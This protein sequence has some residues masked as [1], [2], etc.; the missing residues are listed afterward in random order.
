MNDQ[1]TFHTILK[2]NEKFRNLWLAQFI[3]SIGD[4]ANN[5]AVLAL[6][7]HL[8]DSGLQAGLVILAGN[9]AAIVAGPLGGSL[10]DKWNPKPILIIS[11]LLGALLSLGYL[12]INESGQII[13]V[14]ILGGMLTI[15]L[16]VFQIAYGVT[17]PLVA[18]RKELLIAN[19]LIGIS[20][21]FV[22]AIGSLLGG[23][24]STTFG[25]HIPFI[26]NCGTFLISALLIFP[27][28]VA[29]ISSDAKGDHIKTQSQKSLFQYLRQSP[30]EFSTLFLKPS[31]ALG[32][33][34]IIL[35]VLFSIEIFESGDIGTGLLYGA[36]GG[37]FVLSAI[38]L[39]YIR[40]KSTNQMI[41]YIAGSFAIL[42]FGYM[43][44]AY[45]PNLI[46]GV[47]ILIVAHVGGGAIYPLSDTI[48]QALIPQHFLGRS[49][50]IEATL[51]KIILSLSITLTGWLSD[52][53]PIKLVT[54]GIGGAYIIVCVAWVIVHSAKSREVHYE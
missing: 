43:A 9:L 54:F 51:T 6:V 44:F 49:Y 14:Y 11:N 22:L 28:N 13:W 15:N 19:S 38:L 20:S 47:F 7:I 52:V 23:T 24:L 26:F 34:I 18:S 12:F 53:F 5:L 1:L 17:I 40:P 27:L 46:W 16:I 3:N 30:L 41:S 25:R 32:S 48:K 8:T 10:V 37:G 36:R 39:R 2:N 31:F 33:S 50:G 45:A 42:S 35:F 4:W 29:S 21:G